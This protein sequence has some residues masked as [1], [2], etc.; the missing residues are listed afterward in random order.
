MGRMNFSHDPL[1]VAYLYKFR[2]LYIFIQLLSRPKGLLQSSHRELNTRIPDQIK[3]RAS[4]A[5]PASECRIS[6]ME[7]PEIFK[8]GS[9]V[10]GR[11]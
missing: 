5:Q 4:S 10:I 8:D 1:C 11:R 9:Y 6:G 2:A 3:R 7:A